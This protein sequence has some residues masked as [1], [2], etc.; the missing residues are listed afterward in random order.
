MLATGPFIF[1]GEMTV[2][3]GH[4]PKIKVFDFL[5]K[6]SCKK[7]GITFNKKHPKQIL[8]FLFTCLGFLFVK[9]LIIQI[10]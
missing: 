3:D 1:Q 6:K 9:D 8:P 5:T 7:K 2:K 10:D 4:Q